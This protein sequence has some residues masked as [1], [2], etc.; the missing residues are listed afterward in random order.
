MQH[1]HLE[2]RSTKAST[3]SNNNTVVAS[4]KGN[5]KQGKTP[6]NQW[7]PL[8]KSLQKGKTPSWNPKGYYDGKYGETTWDSHSHGAGVDRGNGPQDGHWDTG[9]GGRFNRE[10]LQIIAY[11]IIGGVVAGVGYVVNLV[12]SNPEILM[13]AF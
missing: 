3:N 10:G 7:P 6:N 5:R 11:G 2:Q 12:Q 13:F 4:S 1:Q 9:T 8:P